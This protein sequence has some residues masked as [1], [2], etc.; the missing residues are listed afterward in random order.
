MTEILSVWIL[1]MVTIV[2]A[3]WYF[4]TWS[5]TRPPLGT[6]N[7]G[8]IT[9]T[10]VFVV[11]LPFLYLWLPGW[12]LVTMLAV[13]SLSILWFVAEP[14][15]ASALARWGFA[16]GLV[17]AELLLVRQ[18]TGEAVFLLANNVVILVMVVGVSNVWAQGGLRARDLAIFAGA[19]AVYDLIATGVFPLTTDMIER[20]AGF[21]FVPMVV[22][23][24]GDG[25]W[26]GIGMGDL[27]MAA[28]GPL[29]L[30]KAFGRAA[31]LAAMMLALGVIASV[32]LIA[33]WGTVPETFPTMVVLGPVMIA[34]YLWLGRRYGGERTYARYLT[35]EPVVPKPVIV[36]HG[37]VTADPGPR[38]GV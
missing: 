10:L 9:M 16:G 7:L 11:T 12:I 24:A 37:M 26:T 23:P 20:L 2:A 35:E 33:R 15:M 19:I 27:L 31:G 32:L 36:H 8:D 17:I 21:P 6:V 28:V 5:M 18:G 38:E 34:Q 3:W 13:T 1:A 14:I 25:Q 30:R 29:V 4:R 22:W